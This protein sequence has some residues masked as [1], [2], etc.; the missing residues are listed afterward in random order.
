MMPLEKNNSLYYRE[1]P[2]EVPAVGIEPTLPKEHDFESRASTNSATP[3][4]LEAGG[5]SISKAELSRK[6][7]D[8]SSLLTNLLPR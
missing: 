6:R 5:V 3:A 8:K 7:L 4:F 1:N 2:K